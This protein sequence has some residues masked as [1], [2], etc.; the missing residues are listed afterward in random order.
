MK[1]ARGKPAEYDDLIVS[2]RIR[3]LKSIPGFFGPGFTLLDVGCGNGA[4]IAQLN[5][6]FEHCTGIDIS[7]PDIEQFKAVISDQG[8]SNCEAHV[9]NAD[10]PILDGKKFHRLISFEVL[11]HVDHDVTVAKN[12]YQALTDNGMAAITV[13]NKCWIFETH[14]AYLPLL[15]WNRVPFFSWL[16]TRIHEKY[17]KARIYS[18]RRIINVLKEAGFTILD[19]YY[20]TAPMDVIKWDGLRNFL[21]KTIFKKQ[22]TKIPFLATAIMVVARK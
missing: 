7:T 2:R 11:E 4:S 15:P 19:S 10:D 22:T 13:P 9:I 1:V 17:A 12:M 8:L 20:V 3:I 18:K 16:P 5:D 6:Q 21:R 14:G